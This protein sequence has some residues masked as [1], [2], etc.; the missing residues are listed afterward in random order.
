M[1]NFLSVGAVTQSMEFEAPG[2]TLVL[3]ENLDQGGADAKN[4]V[5]KCLRGSTQIT[6]GFHNADTEKKFKKFMSKR[7]E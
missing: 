5:G 4:G 3:G 1:K 6:V 2:L 7:K